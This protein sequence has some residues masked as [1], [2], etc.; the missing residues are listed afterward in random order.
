MSELVLICSVVTLILLLLIINK[1]KNKRAYLDLEYKN[2]E[3]IQSKRNYIETTKAPEKYRSLNSPNV[4]R[5]L[6][7]K[8]YETPSGFFENTL[9]ISEDKELKSENFNNSYFNE[10]KDANINTINNSRSQFNFNRSYS[11]IVVNRNSVINKQE[12]NSCN[13]FTSNFNN[14]NNFQ[15][16]E[17]KLS[18]YFE[19]ENKTPKYKDQN[20]IT[21]DEVTPSLFK[22]INNNDDITTKKYPTSYIEPVKLVENNITLSQKNNF[23]DILN[24]LIPKTS[25]KMDVVSEKIENKENVSIN[26]EELIPK[27]ITFNQCNSNFT[28]KS[29]SSQDKCNFTKGL[30]FTPTKDCQNVNKDGKTLSCF[31]SF[32]ESIK[33][34]TDKLPDFNNNSIQ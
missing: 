18:D 28:N 26:L 29:S 11:N 6:L 15:F 30:E 10:Y 24:E 7:R 20:K 33:Q 17:V 32:G 8:N 21:L 4:D 16:K 13:N 31:E 5:Y 25:Q 12:S 27:K 3:Q 2:E 1:N 19:D 22:F 23:Q 9:N 14:I 34:V